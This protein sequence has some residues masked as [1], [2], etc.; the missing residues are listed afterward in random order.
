MLVFG[1]YSPTLTK[2]NDQVQHNQSIEESKVIKLK[3]L[4]VVNI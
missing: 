4:K 3:I 2:V 1:S